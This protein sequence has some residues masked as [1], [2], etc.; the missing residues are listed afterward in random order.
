MT[1]FTEL[2]HVL[3]T[4]QEFDPPGVGARDLQECLILQLER[5]RA[6]EARSLALTILDNHFVEFQKRHFEK[7]GAKLGVENDE[8]QAAVNEIKKLNPKPANAAP[9]NSRPTEYVIPDF[10]ITI[11]N[12]KVELTINSKDIPDLFVSKNYKE[13]LQHYSSSKGQVSKKQQEEV[14]FIK[15]K[16]TAAQWFIEAI[17]Q[18]QHTLY[19]TMMA[20]IDRQRNYFLTGDEKELKPMILKDI[21]DVIQMDISTVSRV[22]NNKYVQTPYGT[23]LVKQ[24]FSESMTNADGEDISTKEIKKTLEE[25]I[26]DEDKRK[27]LTDEALSKLLKEKGYPVARRTVAKY[28][29]QLD[30]PVARMRKQVS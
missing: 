30:L 2:D 10:K 12:G 3:S 23:F 9:N 25:L 7:L 24:L 29:E 4:I 16:L 5:K 8:L 13:A 6:T 28:R 11:E 27:P 20:I 19:I 17:K 15:H 26:E 21:A 18:R 1:N 22:A 14:N